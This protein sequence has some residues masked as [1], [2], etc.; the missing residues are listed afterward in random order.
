M[1][2]LINLQKLITDLEA[3]YFQ[4]DCDRHWKNSHQFLP[5]IGI[6]ND[7]KNWELGFGGN[8]LATKKDKK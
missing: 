4:K 5:N 3:L 6:I 1:I 7:T 2:C 8:A